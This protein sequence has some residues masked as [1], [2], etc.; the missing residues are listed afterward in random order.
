MAVAAEIA[1]GVAVAE[2]AIAAA[3]VAAIRLVEAGAT[4][5]KAES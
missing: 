2:A 5:A 4:I 1:A 3:A